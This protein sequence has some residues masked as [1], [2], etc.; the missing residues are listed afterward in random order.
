MESLAKDGYHNRRSLE[1]RT[2]HLEDA[3]GERPIAGITSPEMFTWLGKL[4]TQSGC[5]PRTVRNIFDA[6]KYMFQFARSSGYLIADRLSIVEQLKRPRATS[7]KK[8]IYLASIMQLLL[9]A[10]WGSAS[11]AATALAS[12]AFAA[13]R[14][15]ELY[16][17][18]A[19]KP[20]ET[21]LCWEDFYWKEDVIKVRPETDKNKRGRIVPIRKNLRQM[22]YPLRGKGPLYTEVRLDLEYAELA[23]KAGVVW[24]ANAHRHSAIT[25]D[26][27]VSPNPAEVANRSGNSL[28]VIESNYRNPFATRNQAVAWFKL[29]PN[30]KWGSKS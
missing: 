9:D 25:Y 16:T 15:E 1:D 18:D 2:K 11:S 4:K 17:E 14:S 6:T 10:A 3:F 30:A 23:A 7:T 20:R 26:L 29:R 12:T 19:S 24:K 28:A 5:A 27:L 8:E 13:I 22:L 21:R